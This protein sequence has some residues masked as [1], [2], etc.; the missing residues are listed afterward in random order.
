MLKF[1]DTLLNSCVKDCSGNPFYAKLELTFLINN[2]MRFYKMMWVQINEALK[3]WSEKPDFNPECFQR[4]VTPK[5]KK[6]HQ[7]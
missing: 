3:D 6:Y 1:K 4:K 5:N 2:S 7:L